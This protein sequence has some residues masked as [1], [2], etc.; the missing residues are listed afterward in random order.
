M[1]DGP[2]PSSSRAWL[3]IGT[4]QVALGRTDEAV[5]AWERAADLTGD[6]VR[7]LVNLGTLHRSLGR[8][9]EAI[10]AYRRA[11]ERDPDEPTAIAALEALGVAVDAGG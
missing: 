6:D 10:A 2:Y 7:A 9:D 8:T 4:A 5:A 1:L 3:G 11:L